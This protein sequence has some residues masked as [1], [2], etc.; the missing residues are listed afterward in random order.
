MTGQDKKRI[1]AS[2][3][4]LAVFLPMLLFSSLHIHDYG[5]QAEAECAQCVNHLPHAGHLMAQD[6][7]MHSCVLCQFLSLSFLAVTSVAVVL[8]KPAKTATSSV[9]RSMIGTGLKGCVSLRAP[10]FV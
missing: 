4:L 10:P 9:N 2:W 7:A 3:V 5:P 6:G 8:F 1:R